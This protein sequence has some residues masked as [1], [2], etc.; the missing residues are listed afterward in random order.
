[1]DLR[2]FLTEGPDACWARLLTAIPWILPPRIRRSIGERLPGDAPAIV[3][4]SCNSKAP[5]AGSNRTERTRPPAAA[6]TAGSRRVA[7]ARRANL[8]AY[9]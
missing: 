9:R 1:M 5:V 8:R 6:F 7:Q 3:L 4:P 2:A